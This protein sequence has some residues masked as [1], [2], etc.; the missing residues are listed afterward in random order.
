MRHLLTRIVEAVPQ[1][2]VRCRDQVM[3]DDLVEYD[4][5]HDVEGQDDQ[6][7]RSGDAQCMLA[8]LALRLHFSTI[9]YPVPRTVS[10]RALLRSNLAGAGRCGRQWCWSPRRRPR[11]PRPAP[12]CSDGSVRSGFYGGGARPGRTR[13]RS[14]PRLPA[15]IVSLEGRIETE[16]SACKYRPD[17]EWGSAL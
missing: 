13:W 7:G 2:I 3:G 10:M 6:S 8:M 9:L 11:C 14:G 12:R 5:C 17:C 1:A 16:G 4:H 15:S